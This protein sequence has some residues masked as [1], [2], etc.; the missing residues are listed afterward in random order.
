MDVGPQGCVS[1]DLRQAFDSLH[2]GY[3]PRTLRRYGIPDGYVNWIKVLYTEPTARA[4]TSE[5]I[6]QQYAIG[7]GTRQGCP[8]SPLLFVLAL[9]PLVTKLRRTAGHRGI[10]V[11][12]STHIASA[13]AD[14]LILYIDNLRWDLE[15]IPTIF[16]QFSLLSGLDIN[17]T[18]SYAYFFTDTE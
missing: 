16:R 1:V 18:K 14:D 11:G 7:R 13:Y 12:H 3:M 17:E 8:L 5:H 2:W 9:E 6:S 15:P 4:R 10:R